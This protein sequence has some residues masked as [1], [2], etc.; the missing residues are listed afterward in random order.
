MAFLGNFTKQPREILDC[1]LDYSALLEGRTADAI[2]N[3]IQSEV[4]PIE[5]NGLTV[6][7][8]VRVDNTIKVTVSGGVAAHTYK[9]TILS[10]TNMGLVYEYEFNVLVGES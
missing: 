4:F 8:T 2:N 6:I 1:C 5:V 9:V 7:E 10:E 3:S